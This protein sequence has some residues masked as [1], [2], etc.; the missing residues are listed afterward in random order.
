MAVVALGLSLVTLAD[1]VAL[2]FSSSVGAAASSGSVFSMALLT[3]Y[4]DTGYAGLFVLMALE[5]SA[6]PIPSEV[7]L[8]LAGYLVF[9]GKMNLGLA[10]LVATTAGLVGSVVDYYLALKLGRPIVYRILGR[11]GVSA[12]RIDDGERWVDS[13]GAWSIFVG[14][15]IPGVRSIISIPAGLL[16]MKVGPFVALTVAGSLAWSAVL[17][18]VGYSAGS[19]WQSALGSFT[20]YADQ[21]GLLLVAAVSIL[22][23][24]YY[25]GAFARR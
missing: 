4:L 17:I 1:V 3:S 14:R 23:V 22:Y 2:P 5:S 8:P 6:F 12:R 18:Y 19:L 9:L 11:L 13:K 25:L 15:L 10:I 21:L 16:R 20:K 24:L 7:V